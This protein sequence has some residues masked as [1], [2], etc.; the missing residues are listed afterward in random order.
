M[1]DG[2]TV[3][4]L[5]Q[6]TSKVSRTFRGR[7]MTGVMVVKEEDR[8]M[9]EINK[10]Q[11]Q[12]VE[13]E[14][15]LTDDVEL[16]Q[17]QTE[18]L[19]DF[20]MKNLLD[21][22]AD[23]PDD[24][25]LQDMR[26]G[27]DGKGKPF[28]LLINPAGATSS[29]QSA[30]V[31]SAQ[32]PAAETTAKRIKDDDEDDGVAMASGLLKM[33]GREDH[34]K[35]KAKAKAGA[36]SG[37]RATKGG[38]PKPP[39]GSAQRASED[40]SA[41]M[42][43]MQELRNVASGQQGQHRPAGEP[44]QPDAEKGQG[45]KT[46]RGRKSALDVH[47]S[48]EA[49]MSEVT[50]ELAGVTDSEAMLDVGNDK[51]LSALAQTRSQ[52]CI[53]ISNKTTAK[54]VQVKRRRGAMSETFLAKVQ[55]LNS[56][57]LVFS[58][59]YAEL[60]SLAPK[61]SELSNLMG[62]ATNHGFDRGK[63]AGMKLLK[64]EIMDRLKYQ[65]Y[66]EIAKE[67][68]D[69]RA[70]AMGKEEEEDY[71]VGQLVLTFEQILQK[72]LRAVPSTQARFGAPAVQ[73]VKKFLDALD[74]CEGLQLD[75]GF[76]S[77]LS[78]LQTLFS[79]DSKSVL[80]TQIQAAVAEVRTS[81]P[82]D[83]MFYAVQSLPQGAALLNQ[84]AE[85]AKKRLASESSLIELQELTTAVEKLELTAPSDVDMAGFANVWERLLK[86][87]ETLAEKEEAANIPPLLGKL[88]FKASN[89]I[90]FHIKNEL[91]PFIQSQH[92]HA[93][94]GL[95]TTQKPSWPIV[96]SLRKY[97]KDDE[98]IFRTEWSDSGLWGVRPGYVHTQV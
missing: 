22:A 8:G 36:K 75:P 12:S 40:N 19:Y 95:A 35:A 57:A 38:A 4:K 78:T 96:E 65:K 70:R 54:L 28:K 24:F 92:V 72:L 42:M 66:A 88:N 80:P 48:D 94:N 29:R 89:M 64:A 15:R 87:K 7:T 25:V 59:L 77:Q 45:K 52:K 69:Y 47:Q 20:A 71:V 86:L 6:L 23:A 93:K 21:S 9:Y 97:L 43:S 63:V 55:E 56:T 30:P 90:G 83:R 49:F 41:P 50:G 31:P 67:A 13:M 3:P 61:A 39:G 73:N 34:G 76:H 11:K 44:E 17:G 60:S 46:G 84:A 74:A 58:R 62:Q 68:C 51:E 14:T 1:L 85:K 26:E 91:V 82:K 98:P 16:R 27:S 2:F 81:M 33:L 37:A 18:K 5:C 53:D 32:A 10:R 79:H